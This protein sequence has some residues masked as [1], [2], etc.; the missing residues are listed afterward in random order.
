[1]ETNIT[2]VGLLAFL[3]ALFP[4]A[5]GAILAVW[6]K[7]GE[8]T[9]S[10]LSTLRKIILCIVVIVV[11]VVGTLISH[12]VSGA[13]LEQTLI[14]VESWRADGLKIFIGLSS[15][16]ILDHTIKNVDPLLETIFANVNLI[17]NLIFKGITQKIKSIFKMGDD[18]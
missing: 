5:F 1:M 10:D 3:K 2:T 13:I 15:L 16:K 8:V 18:E 9:W 11:F 17:I 6:Y 14:P 4:S 12:Y 7:R